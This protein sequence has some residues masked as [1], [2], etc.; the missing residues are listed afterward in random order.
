MQGDV[1][2]PFQAEFD[3]QQNWH[4]KQNWQQKC[5]LH[6]TVQGNSSNLDTIANPAVQI[7]M[8]SSLQKFP[9]IELGKG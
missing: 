2:I 4:F 1:H 3:K 5:E 8:K 9:S 6:Y 7:I